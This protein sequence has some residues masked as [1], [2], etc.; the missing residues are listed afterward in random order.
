[1]MPQIVTHDPAAARVF[2]LHP[3]AIGESLGLSCERDPKNTPLNGVDKEIDWSAPVFQVAAYYHEQVFFEIKDM[4]AGGQNYRLAVVSSSATI[5]HAIWTPVDGGCRS[6]AF[7]HPN[8]RPEERER[9]VLVVTLV[10]VA[11]GS[12]ALAG[13]DGVLAAP[14]VK[15]ARRPVKIIFTPHVG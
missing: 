6:P 1:M 15:H 5:P 14:P 4:D 10:V 7:E 9:L 2:R 3:Y 8:Q 12:R 13:V 11:A